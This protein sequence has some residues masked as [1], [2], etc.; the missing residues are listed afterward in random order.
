MPRFQSR[1]STIKTGIVR[2]VLLPFLRNHA[3]HPSISSLRPEDLDRRTFI[4]NKWWTGLL[5]MLNGRHGESVSGN[6]RPAILEAV[7]AL[8][9]RPEWTLPLSSLATRPIKTARTSLKS[10]STTSLG[11]NMSD[12][13]ADSVHHNVR[14]TFTQ[15]L[16]AQMAYVVDKMSTRNVAASVVTFC[17]K[18]T[19][20]AF[21][22]CESIAE[23][24]VRL[25]ATPSETLRRVLAEGSTLKQPDIDS[26][27]DRVYPAYPQC[28]HS[29]RLKALRPMM[30][31]L[32]S[33]PQSPVPIAT[34]YIPWHGPWVSRWAGKDTD[35]FFVFTKFYTDL[36]CRFLPD[37]PSPEERIAAPAWVLVQA[38]M[39]TILDAT[40]Q[41]TN[42]QPPINQI[43]SSS[44]TFDDFL[45][46]ADA[47]AT[48][49]PLPTHAVVRT[50]GENRMI[51]LLRDCLSSS[52]IMSGKSRSIF[53]QSFGSL[54]KVAARRTSKYDHNA[55]FTLCDFL[56]EAIP[57][58]QRYQQETDA[59]IAIIDW[60]F[61]LE[62]CRHM[63]QS[64]NS[65]TEVRL[66]AFLYSMWSIITSDEARRQE[67][68]LDW[69]LTEEN[70]HANFNH[71]CPM[72]RAFYMRLIV[73]K[74]AR[75]DGS[76]SD[77]NM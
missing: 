2:S 39:L 61:W 66:C 21:F 65:M 4:L 16:L 35:L 70:F 20:Y 53:A 30:K 76:E 9:A 25:W 15:N 74:I 26:V 10:Q 44:V 13:L 5:E 49:L 68:C 46:E 59:A 38:Q 1:P 43:G 47:N 37:D 52:T 41:Q 3:E 34:T 17:G 31:Y 69:L 11:S 27:S 57:I 51:M 8:M 6:D 19:A 36:A 75:L 63:L 40:M 12:F 24:L 33:K 72:V 28:L 45:G 67:V 32:R 71:W 73:W 58:L 48:M 29:L 7:T 50:M 18:A 60:V 55:C 54:I 64:Q 62:V 77:V 56:E 22:Y 23:I 14:N 42:S